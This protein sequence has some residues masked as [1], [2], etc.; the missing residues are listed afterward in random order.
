MY[1]Y[2]YR[3]IPVKKQSTSPSDPVQFSFFLARDLTRFEPVGFASST[4]CVCARV[5]CCV[6]VCVCVCVCLLFVLCVCCVC[7]SGHCFKG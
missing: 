4:V 3:C 1:V 2:V 5:S 7:S 6:C